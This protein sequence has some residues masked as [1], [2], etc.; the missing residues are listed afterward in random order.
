MRE[1]FLYLREVK[2]YPVWACAHEVDMSTSPDLSGGEV[3][4]FILLD[5]LHITDI[6][7]TKSITFNYSIAILTALAMVV[8]FVPA[9]ALAQD[10]NWDSTVVSNMNTASV[11]SGSVAVSNTGG[12]YADGSYGGDGGNGGSI[13]AGDGEV[14]DSHTGSA[15]MG[16][17]AAAGGFVQTGNASAVATTDTDVNSSE[18]EV[19][20]EVVF[21]GDDNA[22]ELAVTNSNSAEVVAFSGALAN[23][24]RNESLGSYGGHGGNA[25]SISSSGDEVDDSS[26]GNGGEGGA[27][28]IGGEVVT[29]ASSSSA[30]TVSVINRTVLR[31]QR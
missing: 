10:D 19:T 8:A 24:G 2:K 31:V 30:S 3:K 22:V 20:G 29:G 12:N 23:T 13:M 4:K 18:I 5:R 14:D 16:G 11:I 17:A 25:G 9:L 21:D 1:R 6:P 7:M 15:G 28:G 26:T 27:G